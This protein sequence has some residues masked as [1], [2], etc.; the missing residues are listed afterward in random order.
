MVRLKG[1]VTTSDYDNHSGHRFCFEV[2]DLWTLPLAYRPAK[3]L[4]F[5]AFYHYGVAPAISTTIVEVRPDGV[6]NARFSNPPYVGGN[7]G[8]V[9]LDGIAFRAGA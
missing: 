7:C 8:W 4:T 6:I 2:G 3:K 1:A 9:S 5:N